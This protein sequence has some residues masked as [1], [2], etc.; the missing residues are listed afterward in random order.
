VTDNGRVDVT[1]DGGTT[2]KNQ[3][4]AGTILERV[5]FWDK[6]H[7]VVVGD[8]GKA[9]WTSNG[10]ATWNVSSTGITYDIHDIAWKD[11]SNLW[12][13]AEGPNGGQ[14]LSSSDAGQT[15]QSDGVDASESMTG[16][17]SAAGAGWAVGN[18]GRI[19]NTNNPC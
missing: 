1:M 5:R 13:A 9:W 3:L 12:I 16:I 14:I 15:F 11:S 7:G 17:A 19:V 2:W 6:L 8:G 10:G 18:Y 4:K